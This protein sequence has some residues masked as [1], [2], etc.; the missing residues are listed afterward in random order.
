MLFWISRL[1]WPLLTFSNC[2][3]LTVLLII[4]NATTAC[5]PCSSI[6]VPAETCPLRR[7]LSPTSITSLLNIGWAVTFCFCFFRSFRSLSFAILRAI[8]S[9]SSSVA[10]TEF[11]NSSKALRASL[12]CSFSA[13]ASLI[14][15]TVFSILALA[16]ARIRWASA[17]AS[18]MISFRCLFTASKSCS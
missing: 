15:R 17:F 1:I 12:V 10:I 6:T 5:F 7:T 14:S 11:L 8:L 4:P 2:S 13:W 3:S 9:S 16:S 18:R